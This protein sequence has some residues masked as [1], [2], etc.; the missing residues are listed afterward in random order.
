MAPGY[1]A[2]LW[3]SAAAAMLSLAGCVS[4]DT[5]YQAL[6]SASRVSGGYADERLAEDRYRVTFAGNTFTSRERVESYLLFRSAELTLQQGFD[7]FLVQD[8]EMDH[9]IEREIRQIRTSARGMV[10]NTKNGGRTGAT[11]PLEQAGRSGI[12]ITAI[13]SGRA[14][15][16][17][18]RSSGSKPRP[19][20]SWAVATP[21]LAR[22]RTSMRAA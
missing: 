12:R 21:R 9:L 2:A 13:A 17:S 4:A 20:S 7:W 8:Q 11:A 1:R 6:S 14:G 3:L 22:A 10:R 5:P 18:G 19:R 16:T 15:S